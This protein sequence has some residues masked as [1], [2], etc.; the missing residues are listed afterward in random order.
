M[1]VYTTEEEQVDAIKKWWADNWKSLA[2]GVLIGVAILF[3]GKA[4]IKQ[5]DL[6]IEAASAEFEAMMQATSEDK[7]DVAADHAAKLLGQ[8]VD[9]TYAV[10]AALTLAKI[11]MEEN[12]LAA[13][14]IHLR[15]AID[16]SSQSAFKHVARLRLARVLLSEGKTD[17]SLATLVNIDAGT[18][19]AS[20]EELKGDIY[21][22]QGKMNQARTAYTLALAAL[23]S[24][25]RGRDFLEMKLDDLGEAQA[26][27]TNGAS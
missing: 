10:A 2:G 12:D 24:S 11:K 18:Y 3:G 13:A 21:L 1:D 26:P 25:A 17:D 22:A 14:K 6:K 23:D 20:Y 19:V 15:W 16:H 9:S 4:W 5:Q 27:I 7:N 8:F